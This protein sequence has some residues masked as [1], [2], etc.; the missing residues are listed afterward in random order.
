MVPN[1]AQLR[2]RLFGGGH[3]KSGRAVEIHKYPSL[4]VNVE[5]NIDT[6]RATAADLETALLDAERL[7]ASGQKGHIA[8]IVGPASVSTVAKAGQGSRADSFLKSL[9]HAP[10]RPSQNGRARAVEVTIERKTFGTKD[11]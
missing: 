7:D 4:D 2:A 11:R 5:I 10:E 8:S 6:L 3:L 9:Q 1:S